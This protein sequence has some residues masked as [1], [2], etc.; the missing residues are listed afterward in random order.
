MIGLDT[1]VLVRYLLEDDEVQSPVAIRT[2]ESRS[3]DDPAF[4]GLVVLAE[5]YW[6]LRR[7]Y[8]VE[9]EAAL[10]VVERLL[11]AAEIMVEDE[12][13]VSRALRLARRGADF[14]DA[15]IGDTALLFGCDTVVTFD[16]K[17]ALHKP[18]E[19]LDDA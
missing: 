4:V 14:A 6:V 10:A 5:T 1:N 13:T 7:A 15:L 9:E 18:F 2:I 17:A 8:R 3:E 11:D 16:R 12:E 19:L